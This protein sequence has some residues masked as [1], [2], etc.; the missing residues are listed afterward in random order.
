MLFETL[1]MA[2]LV[3]VNRSGLIK[4]QNRKSGPLSAYN[5]CDII[6]NIHLS[7][8]DS[9][10]VTCLVGT[11]ILCIIAPDIHLAGLLL[12]EW[13]SDFLSSRF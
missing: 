6:K 9:L 7:K 11:Y 2:N 5:L 8:I 3:E 13:D 10:C 4:G 1:A 12:E